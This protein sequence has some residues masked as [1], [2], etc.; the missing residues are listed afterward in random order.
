VE[1]AD[2]K[3]SSFSALARRAIVEILVVFTLEK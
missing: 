2:V 1:E 3:A